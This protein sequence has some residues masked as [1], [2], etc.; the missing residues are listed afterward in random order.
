MTDIVTQEPAS[1][2]VVLEN[3]EPELG[4]TTPGEVRVKQEPGIEV[5]GNES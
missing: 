3:L 1:K 2:N 4:A 5:V